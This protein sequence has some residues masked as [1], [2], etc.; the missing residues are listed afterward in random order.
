MAS[1]YRFAHAVTYLT[2][3]KETRQK[4]FGDAE[5][6]HEWE[7]YHPFSFA[8][9]K[10]DKDGELIH[11][12]EKQVLSSDDYSDDLKDAI[13]DKAFRLKTNAAVMFVMD[14]T[15]EKTD[16]ARHILGLKRDMI[17]VPLTLAALQAWAMAGDRTYQEWLGALNKTANQWETFRAGR[18]DQKAERKTPGRRDGLT[19]D[20]LI[21]KE[22]G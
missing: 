22:K 5:E 14:S 4:Y 9:K 13:R 7:I 15:C 1:F 16:A 11:L 10:K 3:D 21:E 8:T 2:S 12:T 18:L 20:H 17:T 19:L 6:A